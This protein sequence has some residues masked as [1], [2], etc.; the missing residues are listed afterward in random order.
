MSFL[1]KDRNRDDPRGFADKCRCKL[2]IKPLLCFWKV[3]REMQECQVMNRQHLG[4]ICPQGTNSIR[5]K[6]NIR[7]M[8]R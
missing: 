4:L 6:K 2:L 3:L 8:L 5:G 1:E 7:L